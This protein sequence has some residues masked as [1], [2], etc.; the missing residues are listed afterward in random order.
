MTGKQQPL[1][2]TLTFFE[3]QRRRTKG[4]QVAE[5]QGIV[6]EESGETQS[7]RD[8]QVA[9]LVLREGKLAL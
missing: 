8:T 2:D 5:E 4:R 7:A 3:L 9:S 1:K 6:E